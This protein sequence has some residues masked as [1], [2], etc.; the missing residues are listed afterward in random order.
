M[1]TSAITSNLN[2]LVTVNQ[3][4]S[5]GVNV[6]ANAMAK[7]SLQIENKW[8]NIL[9][10][11]GISSDSGGV[12]GS[13]A[14]LANSAM[15]STGNNFLPVI[16]TSHVWR[17]S[18]GIE[19]QLQMR[20]DAVT[21]AAKDVLQPVQNLIKMFSPTRGGGSLGSWGTG[22][23]TALGAG[24]LAASINSGLFLHPPGPTPA[25]FVGNSASQYTITVQIGR[26][27]S[28]RNLIPTTIKWEIENRYVTSGDPISATVDV[29]FI[30]YTLP[31][32]QEVLSFFLNTAGGGA[33][34]ASQQNAGAVP[35]SGV[36]PALVAP[37]SP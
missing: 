6:Q 22:L 30:S 33:S 34:S 37:S 15:L 29:S 11:L 27:M 25:E 21:D 5:S 28:I 19:L 4:G 9:E 12:G 18:T 3:G 35:G 1:A 17:G 14:T 32:Q 2:Y 31:D 20:F 26:V 24:G 10:A 8:V 13:V 16:A 7:L 23:A 36:N